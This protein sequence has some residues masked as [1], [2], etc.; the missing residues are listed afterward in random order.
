MC[1]NECLKLFD[2]HQGKLCTCPRGW[3]TDKENSI[4]YNTFIKMVKPHR[5][6]QYHMAEVTCWTMQNGCVQSLI[7]I[8]TFGE[9]NFSRYF[10]KAYLRL[11]QFFA[12][13]PLLPV[14]HCM[15]LG[16]CW[17]FYKQVW[18]LH[19]LSI[20]YKVDKSE[21]HYDIFNIIKI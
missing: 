15:Q 6:S 17:K 19:L 7:L 16:A 11:T 21:G 12:K 18:A 14:P 8:F 10:A 13:V 20:A 1:N 2:T 4:P 9:W 3:L 5:T